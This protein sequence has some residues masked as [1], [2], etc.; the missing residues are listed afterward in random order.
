ME[1]K[2][3]TRKGPKITGI[4][5]K[6]NGGSTWPDAAVRTAVGDFAVTRE[7]EEDAIRNIGA[8]VNVYEIEEVYKTVEIVSGITL[9]N[10]VGNNPTQSKMTKELILM[11]ALLEEKVLE[12]NCAE[13][14]SYHYINRDQILTLG[15]EISN[16]KK[17]FYVG[18]WGSALLTWERAVMDILSN[19]NQWEIAEN[20]K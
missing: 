17:Y 5:I 6:H 13:P 20:E 9:K 16:G 14:G 7:Q 2:K 19:P 10:D 18:G 3:Y 12:K 11:Q 8:K 1:K 15:C 4:I